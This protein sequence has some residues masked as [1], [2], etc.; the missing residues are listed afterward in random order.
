MK[1]TV[2]PE[3]EKFVTPLSDA[4]YADLRDSIKK[5]G[6]WIPIITNDKGVILDG[7]HRYKACLETETPIKNA[8]R[9]FDSPLDEII[10][11]G[12]CNLKRRQM[13]SLQ[14]IEIVKKLEPFYREKAKENQGKRN[15]LSDEKS[16]SAKTRDILG[17]K[18]K[19]SG[20]TYEK[21][22]AILESAD[23]ADIDKINKGETTISKVF[24][25]INKSKKR[26]ERHNQIREQQVELPESVTLHNSEFQK[27]FIKG[28]SV[29]LIFTDPPYHDK[30]L[31]LYEDLAI[32]AS[33]VLRDGGSL[34]CY[35]GQSNIG[36]IINMMEAQGLKFHWPITVK[37]TGASASVFGKKVLVACKIMLWFVK[38]KYEG[39]FVRDYIES[40][41]QGKEIHEWAQ[42]TIESDYYIRYMTIENEIVY[43]PFMG[44]GT[45][46][47]SAVKQNRQFIGCETDKDHFANAER[48]IT[49]ASR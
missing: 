2:N 49:E 6:L 39:E 48:I 45:F 23:P 30:Y 24:H 9:I 33:R 5:S 12:E 40:E 21:G 16:Q 18:A 8:I 11:V 35:V 32:H 42:S 14:R 25:E 34:I 22:S 38:G 1:L 43:D 19:V 15:D 36:K 28:N 20:R 47:I 10:F 7:H 4:E 41:F 46:G 29:S 3:Y 44:Q 13:T 26:E 31:Y 27:V 37:H 17:E